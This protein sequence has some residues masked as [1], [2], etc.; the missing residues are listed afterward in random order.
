MNENACLPCLSIGIIDEWKTLQFLCKLEYLKQNASK[1]IFAVKILNYSPNKMTVKITPT[2]IIKKIFCLKICLLIK[3]YLNV[4]KFS[5]SCTRFMIYNRLKMCHYIILT[6]ILLRNEK[7][8][9]P[10]LKK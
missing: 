4:F 2:N 1:L 6:W 5:V 7:V 8:E 9:K 3:F 10:G